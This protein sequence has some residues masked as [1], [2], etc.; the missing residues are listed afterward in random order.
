M[1]DS[2]RFLRAGKFAN[3]SIER[4]QLETIERRVDNE[5]GNRFVRGGPRVAMLYPSPYRAG[6]SSLGFQWVL[7][8]LQDEGMSVEDLGQEIFQLILD[9]A[10][11]KQSKSE[12]F[13]FGD[14]E[15]LP[16]QVGAV[17]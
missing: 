13:G 15:F 6:M 3:V 1:R 4:S 7:S 11:G 12:I 9:T 10:S 8:I 5:R 17:L 2:L 16:W 14:E